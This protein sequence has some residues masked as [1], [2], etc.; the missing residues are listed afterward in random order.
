MVWEKNRAD[1]VG[2]PLFVK[3]PH[4]QEPVV[5][6][7]N[8]EIIDIVPTIADVL[9]TQVPWPLDGQSALD[10]LEPERSEKLMF[11]KVS[12]GVE[13]LVIDVEIEEMRSTVKRKISLF[14]TGEDPHD[15]YRIGRFR[16]LVGRTVETLPRFELQGL[17]MELEHDWSFDEVDLDGTFIPALVAG[18]THPREGAPDR[19]HLAVAVNGTIQAVTRT[20]RG[21]KSE[22]SFTAMVPED[23]FREGRNHVEVFVISDSEGGLRLASVGKKDRPRLSLAQG[24]GATCDDFINSSTGETIPIVP[25][26]MDGAVDV[27]QDLREH[28]GHIRISG[29]ASDG[30]HREPADQVFVFVNGEAHHA[31]HTLVS[32][33]DVA[34]AFRAQSLEA[35]GFGVALQGSV[36]KQDPVPGLRVFAISS[37]GVASELRYRPQYDD[38]FRKRRLGMV[39]RAVRYSLAQSKDGLE[40]YIRSPTGET[41]GIVRGAMDGVVDSV[42]QAERETRIRGWASDGAHRRRADQV[43]IFIN[44]EA[45]HDGYRAVRR[46]DLVTHFKTPCLSQAG[47]NIILPRVVFEQNS[48]AVA[49]VFAISAEGTASELRYRAEYEVGGRKRKLG[50]R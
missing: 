1:I 12:K 25:G 26:A 23:A 19:L 37:T 35:A 31:G 38:G 47:F 33:H 41:I 34:R 43:V 11:R 49:R 13:R 14:G 6:D 29:W 28:G 7:R 3:T 30:A 45:D 22:W 15:I 32:R 5:S 48:A 44:G 42:R 27:V 39:A 50:R 9:G 20:Y 40:E 8:V 16:S 17:E 46:G 4:Q 18:Q 10:P 2:V 36:F 21:P 24:V